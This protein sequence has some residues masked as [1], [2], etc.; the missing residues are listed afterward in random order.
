VVDRFGHSS[1]LVGTRWRAKGTTFE[2]SSGLDPE[3]YAA[4]GGAF[5]LLIRGVG[6]AGTITVSGLP[7][8]DDH[9]LVVRIVRELLR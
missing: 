9:A 8:A 1:Y 7:Q 3:V 4:H 5:P 2:A 6:P